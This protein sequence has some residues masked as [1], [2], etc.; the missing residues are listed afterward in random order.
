[1]SELKVMRMNKVSA[2]IAENGMGP[3]VCLQLF[4]AQYTKLDIEYWFMIT[5]PALYVMQNCRVL[6]LLS[7]NALFFSTY[8]FS[9]Y[10]IELFLPVK[11]V[12]VR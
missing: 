6:L 5:R 7:R 10:L 2:T 9:K 12:M 1:M 11:A 8:V 4:S 3:G